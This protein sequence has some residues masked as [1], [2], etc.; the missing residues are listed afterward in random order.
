MIILQAGSHP[1]IPVHQVYPLCSH[2]GCRGGCGDGD[3]DCVDLQ[4]LEHLGIVLQGGSY[5]YIPMHRA[6]LL[7]SH[8]GC[9]GGCWDVDGGCV[10]PKP[11]EHLGIVLQAGS[12]PYIPICKWHSL[13]AATAAAGVAVGT[14][15]GVVL[16]RSHSSTSA[17]SCRRGE[18]LSHTAWW[19]SF[20]QSTSAADSTCMQADSVMIHQPANELYITY[21]VVESLSGA[22]QRNFLEWY[23]KPVEQ[24]ASIHLIDFFQCATLCYVWWYV[25]TGW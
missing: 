24:D 25:L 10:D 14:L 16:T 17:S 20:S 11:L 7:C 21:P 5:P 8:S 1:H 19:Y 2:S 6:W 23:K 22:D 3:G 13:H 4:P 18:I 15:M 9:R 12:Y